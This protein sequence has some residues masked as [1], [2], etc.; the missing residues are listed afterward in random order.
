M[1]SAP[2]PLTL[3][4]PHFFFVL[5]IHPRVSLVENLAEEKRFLTGAEPCVSATAGLKYTQIAAPGG[6]YRDQYGGV[7]NYGTMHG[8]VRQRSPGRAVAAESWALRMPPAE[9]HQGLSRLAGRPLLPRTLTCALALQ[10][11]GTYRMDYDD[12]DIIESPAKGSGHYEYLQVCC[13]PTVTTYDDEAPVIST[14]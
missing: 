4:L 13:L 12:A 11:L 7:A 9:F 1:V 8:Q 3:L 14:S 10:V 6:S 2:A 5:A